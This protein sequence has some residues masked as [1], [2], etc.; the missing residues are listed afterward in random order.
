MNKEAHDE[1]DYKYAPE[2]HGYEQEYDHDDP[3]QK[4]VYGC[5]N[6]PMWQ[7]AHVLSNGT[8]QNAMC[9]LIGYRGYD[10][11]C[12]IGD[13]EAEQCQEDAG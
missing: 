11:P 2:S 12:C 4:C 13:D 7:F 9:I 8:P 1:Q 6:E 10:S 3:E 5:H